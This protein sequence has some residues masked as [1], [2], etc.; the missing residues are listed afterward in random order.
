MKVVLIFFS[1]SWHQSEWAAFRIRSLKSV[2]TVQISLW[3]WREEKKKPLQATSDTHLIFNYHILT[4][5]DTFSSPCNPL[6]LLL[7]LH[8][9]PEHLQHLHPSLSFT[10][11]ITFLLS[12]PPSWCSHNLTH[13]IFSPPPF[14]FLRRFQHLTICCTRTRSSAVLIFYLCFDVSLT[15]TLENQNDVNKATADSLWEITSLLFWSKCG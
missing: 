14:L 11:I 4:V 5:C 15:H 9:S 10:S 3:L 7:V 2:I 6:I 8:S 1:H 12:P 13:S